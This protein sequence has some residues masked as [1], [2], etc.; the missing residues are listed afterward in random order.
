MALGLVAHPVPWLAIVLS[1]L[2]CSMGIAAFVGAYLPGTAPRTGGN[3]FGAQSGAAAQGCLTALV[4]FVAPAVLL[5]PV[6]V[7]AVLLSGTAWSWLSVVVGLGW[8]L[9]V[10][11]G[12]IVLGG[13]RL[14][15]KG[16]EMLGLLARAQM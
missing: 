14:D 3:P 1:G 8:G 4:S 7:V 11:T 9:V 5:I 16:P 6:V 13:R 12:G 15:A 10:V 2:L